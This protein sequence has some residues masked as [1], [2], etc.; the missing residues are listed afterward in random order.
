MP[1]C[2]E[3]E[4][5]GLCEERVGP[6]KMIRE[7]QAHT[8]AATRLLMQHGAQPPAD[9]LIK[10]AEDA[11]VCMLEVAEPSTQQ[12]VEITDDTRERLPAGSSR[13]RPDAVLEPVQTLLAD[14]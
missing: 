2:V 4:Q 10:P 13:L 5:P 3:F 12:W 8:G 1:G 9:E 11:G 14:K 7:R 6:A